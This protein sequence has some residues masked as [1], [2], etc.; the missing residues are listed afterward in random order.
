MYF[1][2]VAVCFTCCILFFALAIDQYIRF[3]YLFSKKALKNARIRL[4]DGTENGA[5]KRECSSLEKGAKIIVYS[6]FPLFVC[7]FFISVI[8]L[9][10]GIG[11]GENINFFFNGFVQIYV[12]LIIVEIIFIIS[13]VIKKKKGYKSLSLNNV[14]EERI[15]YPS[16]EIIRK[17]NAQVKIIENDLMQW[18][19]TCKQP[20]KDYKISSSA[21]IIDNIILED[22]L[23]SQDYIRYCKRILNTEIVI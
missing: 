3:D 23:K 19:K 12:L 10:I 13:D 14:L 4:T 20:I 17:V 5:L 9:I 16:E 15:S 21:V 22:E 18:Q 7:L 6:C 2:I 11:K 1:S 8:F